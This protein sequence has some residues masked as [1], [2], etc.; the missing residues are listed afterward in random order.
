MALLE[1]GCGRRFVFLEGDE[2]YGKT[3]LLQWFQIQVAQR[4]R[5]VHFD[6]KAPHEL[7]SPQLVVAR[8]VAAI[9]SERFTAY[10]AH[11]KLLM[12]TP[13]RTEVTHNTITG[14]H[15]SV[16]A[17][18]R[19]EQP[20]D[21]LI[22][23]MQLSNPFI[24]DLKRLPA[25]FP[26]FVLSF[27]GYNPVNPD[28]AMVQMNQWLDESFL[29]GVWEVPQARVIVSGRLVPDAATK[30]WAGASA[31]CHLTGVSDVDEWLNVARILQKG[32]PPKAK[33]NPA[34]YLDTVV[35]ALG[36]HPGTIM[37]MI[38]QKW[39]AERVDG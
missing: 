20:Q 28:Q 30:P 23:A 4:C 5:V 34:Q 37:R 35:D 24:A 19:P 18:P 3:W 7:L 33:D 22:S 16:V 14:S 25:D 10:E 13:I 39:P 11:W 36:G 6:L 31:K 8:C 26:P 29:P 17:R 32:F 12:S 9:G 1:V 2:D 15:I 27:D 21:Q 38:L